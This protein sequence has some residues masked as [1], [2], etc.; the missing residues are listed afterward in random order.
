MKL[1]RLLVYLFGAKD[2]DEPLTP[3]EAARFASIC[4]DDDDWRF[5]REQD[6]ADREAG[7]RATTDRLSHE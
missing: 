6:S 1:D 7:E 2:G 4:H 5:E 3:E